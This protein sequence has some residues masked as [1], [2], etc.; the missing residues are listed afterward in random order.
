[1]LFFSTYTLFMNLSFLRLNWAN[2]VLLNQKAKWNFYTGYYGKLERKKK[3][4]EDD[5]KVNLKLALSVMLC[6]SGIY[7]GSPAVEWR[8]RGLTFT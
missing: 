7:F 1:M 5:G 4:K 3:L 6:V 8:I 2:F